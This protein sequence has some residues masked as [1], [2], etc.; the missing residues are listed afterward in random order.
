MKQE[1]QMLGHPKRPVLFIFC[2][3]VG[4]ILLLWNACAI[5]LIH[6]ERV[7]LLDDR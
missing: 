4:A 6:G 7:F 3:I 5:D 2:G 1:S